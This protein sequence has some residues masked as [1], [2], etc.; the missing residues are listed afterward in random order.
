MAD[1]VTLTCPNCGGKLE[2]TNDIERFAC[3]YCGTEHVVRRSGGVVSLIAIVDG[4]KGVKTGVDK[5]A[6]ELAI[7][8]LEG[9]LNNLISNRTRVRK[10]TGKPSIF[11]SLG[12]TLLIGFLCSF[13]FVLA[14]NLPI[15]NT[16]LTIVLFV[17][18]NALLYR[19][20]SLIRSE[21]KAYRQNIRDLDME[22][23][24]KHD[25]LEKHN[26]IVRME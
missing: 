19:G 18:G 23:S 1:F 14:E 21:N 24:K 9:E 25:E 3:S 6:S 20:I 5:T 11:L 22:I 16:I 17:L 4:L 10:H 12:A 8:R 2:I 13:I 7:K 15:F 26:A